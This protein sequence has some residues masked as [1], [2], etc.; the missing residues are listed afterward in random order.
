MWHMCQ[1]IFLIMDLHKIPIDGEYR[2]SGNI[3]DTLLN[4]PH[5]VVLPMLVF[6]PYVLNALNLL[7]LIHKLAG[8]VQI[9]NNNINS[10]LQ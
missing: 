2:D 6:L 8:G 9:D 5:I 10:T 3:E 1:E 4:W 7:R